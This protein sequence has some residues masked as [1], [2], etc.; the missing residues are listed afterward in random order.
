MRNV[1]KSVKL[2]EQILRAYYKAFIYVYAVASVPAIIRKTPALT[3]AFALVIS[4]PIVG[5]FFSVYEKNNLS[6][7]YGILPVRRSEVVVGRYMYALILG[8]VSGAV[9][10][11]LAYVISLFLHLG[12]DRLTLAAVL[13]ASLLYFCLFLAILFPIYFRYGFSRVYLVANLPIYIL[14]I[15]SIYV[16]KRTDL[17]KRMGDAVRY[18]T[19]HQ[20]MIWISGIGLGLVLLM[21][22]CSLSCLI[23]KRAEL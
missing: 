8:I 7:L 3:V 13:S 20:E 1:L 19:A 15:L 18:F 21:V 17:L 11:V 9:A 4:A 16:F 10:T 2:D 14:A 12:L 6:K 23:Y 5:L 22:S